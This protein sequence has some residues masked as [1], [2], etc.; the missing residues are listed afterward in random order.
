MDVSSKILLIGNL[1]S[2][3]DEYHNGLRQNMCYSLVV[4][5]VTWYYPGFLDKKF[6]QGFFYFVKCYWDVEFSVFSTFFWV[7][8]VTNYFVC[9]HVE[10]FFVFEKH[11]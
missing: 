10:S 4:V 2:Y 1:V 11:F 9:I 5:L 8:H 7:G 6:L 3:R